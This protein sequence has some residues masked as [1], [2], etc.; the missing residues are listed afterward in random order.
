MIWLVVTDSNNTLR[1]FKRFS[2]L[3]SQEATTPQ[4]GIRR[5]ILQSML[6]LSALLDLLFLVWILPSVHGLSAASF[7]HA[8]WWSSLISLVV[9]LALFQV[10]R[11]GRVQLA[12]RIF[13]VFAFLATWSLLYSKLGE[14]HDVREI[15]RILS[16]LILS[17]MFCGLLLDFR[18]NLVFATANL[19]GLATLPLFLDG[20]PMAQVVG[21]SVMFAFS[22]LLSALTGL[23]HHLDLT[24]IVASRKRTE[25][26]V[27]ELEGQILAREE[28]EKSKSELEDALM[29]TQRREALARMA[30]G[31]AHDFNNAL[32]GVMGQL[33]RIRPGSPTDQKI[34]IDEAIHAV[35]RASGL[36]KGMLTLTH[37]QDKPAQ[38]HPSDLALLMEE[39]RSLARGA[40]HRGIEIEM[41]VEQDVWVMA[42]EGQIVQVIL[43]LC[44]NARDA[45]DSR[46]YAGTSP[47]IVLS[48]G[49]LDA[50][51]PLERGLAERPEGYAWIQ[52]ED[53][54]PGIA[55]LTRDKIFDPFFTTKEV[56]KGS[57]LGLWMCDAIAR[58]LGGQ[59]LLMPQKESSGARFRVYLPLCEPGTRSS[60]SSF[61]ETTSIRTG[62]S[63]RIILVD[64]DDAVREN[65]ATALAEAGWDV[66]QAYDGLD[67]LERFRKAPDNFRLMVLD[68]SLPG[69]SGREVLSNVRSIRPQFPILVISGYDI[70]A[71]EASP[72]VEGANG[73][74]LKPFRTKS[75]LKEIE[76]IEASA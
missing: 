5:R 49:R 52:V 14:S 3:L 64:D 73:R 28:A 6:L 1:P 45:L 25:A 31:F 47:R 8:E 48:M 67:A 38:G 54:G 15:S 61:E 13:V 63:G 62:R 11:K 71:G 58:G 34:R 22:V 66:E 57:G 30:G 55:A 74:L 4:D 33:E 51:E 9:S 10:A 35:E 16:I 12:S 20:I 26:S 72:T 42:D 43:N 41:R 21:V 39:A 7:R 17:Q 23:L 53:N 27:R 19:L 32:M 68:L 76:R 46:P 18:T 75:L 37:P 70:N 50:T 29:R 59:I 44:V 24:E 60:M 2:R 69:M 56:G 36:I 40:V 65:M